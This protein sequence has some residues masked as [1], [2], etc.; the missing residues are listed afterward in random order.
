MDSA[1]GRRPRMRRWII[2]HSYFLLSG[3]L[4]MLWQ[5]QAQALRVAISAED[6]PPFYYQQGD[7]LSGFSVE[8]LQAVANELGLT[9]QWQRLPWNRVVQQ[10]ASGKADV[11]TVLYKTDT[12]ATQFYYSAQSYLRDAIVLLC[13]QPCPHQFDGNLTSLLAQPVAVVR[14][15]SYGELLDKAEFSKAAV[16]E[17]D[18]MMFKLLLSRRLQLG[19]ASLLTIQHAADLK[20]AVDKIAVLHPP[21]DFV[22]IYF[23]FSRQ[24][25]VTPELVSRFD[26]ELGQFKSSAAYSALLQRYKLN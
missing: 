15:F 6:Y 4:L 10:V 9:L 16:V 2:W 22:D 1:I 20:Q 3:L 7:T 17:S 21:L 8:V 19:I 12:R 11:I 13:A 5:L 18:P 23:A 25:A 14:G 26:R 24:S